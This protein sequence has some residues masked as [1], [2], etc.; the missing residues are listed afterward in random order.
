M[1]VLTPQERADVANAI[2][3]VEYAKRAECPGQISKVQ[4]AA[5]IAAVDDWWETTGAA[6]A[7]AAIPQP[8]RGLL[9]PKQKAVLFMRILERR[10]EVTA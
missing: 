6:A 9:T 3:R 5:V 7:N 10:Y 2:Q 8:Q 4:L 1:A